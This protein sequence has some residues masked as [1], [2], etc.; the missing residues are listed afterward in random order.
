MSESQSAWERREWLQ[1]ASFL[2]LHQ[3]VPKRPSRPPR[4]LQHCV[5]LS[6]IKS[7]RLPS[8]NSAIAP[9]RVTGHR[10]YRTRPSPHRLSVVWTS[11]SANLITPEGKRILPSLRADKISC[12]KS[13]TNLPAGAE[14]LI[15]PPKEDTTAAPSL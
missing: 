12:E 15:R 14:N 1:A 11:S 8:P 4:R 13:S 2:V 9:H 6:K 10:P 3:K 5:L 7:L